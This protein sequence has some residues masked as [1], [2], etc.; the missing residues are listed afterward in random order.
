[1][2]AK[3][4]WH[5]RGLDESGQRCE[6]ARWA[7]DRL[8]VADALQAEQIF[9]LALRRSA[10]RTAAWRGTHRCE[11]VHQLATLLKAGLT[12]PDALLMLS[13][14]HPVRQWQALLQSLA[15]DLAQGY[16]ALSGHAPL[17]GRLSA[18]LYRHDPHRGADRRAG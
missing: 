9:I 12:L 3:Q 4:L 17:A 13:R 5:W 15:E 18:D 7:A 6:G 8:A 1:M 10:V 11:V 2:Q 16:R 14:Q